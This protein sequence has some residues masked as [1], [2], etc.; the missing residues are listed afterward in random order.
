[1]HS[2]NAACFVDLDNDEYQGTLTVNYSSES[3]A[4]QWRKKGTT[5]GLSCTIDMMEKKRVMVDTWNLQNITTD[6]E[7]YL[8]DLVKNGIGAFP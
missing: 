4:A 7:K 1:M 8:K 6:Q 5:T 3:E 2:K